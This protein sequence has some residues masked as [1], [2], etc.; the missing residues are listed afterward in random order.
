VIEPV[1]G[2]KTDDG[3]LAFTGAVLS[4]PLLMAAMLAFLLSLVGFA[5]WRVRLLNARKN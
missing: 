2:G 4:S 3:A 1:D 5:A